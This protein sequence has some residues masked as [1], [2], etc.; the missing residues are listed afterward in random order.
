[1]IRPWRTRARRVLLERRPWLTIGEEDVE[2]PD[3]RLIRDFPWIAEREFAIV[4]ALTRH[5]E[6]ILTRSYKHGVR[7]VALSCPA[8]YLEDREG[9]LAAARRELRE[10]TGYTSEGWTAL[11]RFTVDGN[12]GVST[13][14]AFL[15]RDADKIGEPASGDLEEIEVVVLPWAD[16]LARL[17]AGEVRQLSSAGALAL[18][19]IA[20]GAE[21]AGVSAG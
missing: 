16:A 17:A 21:G 2:L 1:M 15:A 19:A 6:V 14:H 12:Y 5:D 10:E 18:A 4:V 20:R 3:G 7:A 9:A 13:M 11:G 8:G